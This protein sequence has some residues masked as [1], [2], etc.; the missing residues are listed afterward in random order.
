M[1][2]IRC[3]CCRKRIFDSDGYIDLNLKG[4]VCANDAN[5]DIE[6]KCACGNIVT[7]KFSVRHELRQNNKI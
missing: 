3:P 2:P 7:A 1:K 6:I 5:P 4:M